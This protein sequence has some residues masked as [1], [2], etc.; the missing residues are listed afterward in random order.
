MTKRGLSLIF[1]RK[2]G[3]SPFPEVHDIAGS[4]VEQRFANTALAQRAEGRRFGISPLTPPVISS[5]ISFA[6]KRRVRGDAFILV[7]ALSE[8]Y[9]RPLFYSLFYFL[10][11]AVEPPRA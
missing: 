1:R 11:R 6:G 7:E 2:M 8:K 9:V 5:S 10:A 4:D 3:L